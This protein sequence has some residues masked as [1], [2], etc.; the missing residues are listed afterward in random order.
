[1]ARPT[2]TALIDRIGNDISTKVTGGTKLLTRALLTA[3]GRAVAGVAHGLYGYIAHTAK[4]ILPDT[5]D[6]AMLERHAYWKGGGMVKKSA[7]K[8]TGT[9]TFTGGASATILAGTEVHAADGTAY[10]TNADGTLAAG[11]VDIVVTAVE[12]GINDQAAGVTLTLTSPIAGVNS[13]ATV[14]AGGLTGGTDQETNAQLL[15][16]LRQYVA[17]APAGGK[18]DDYVSW[19]LEVAGVT[20]A[21]SYPLEDGDGKVKMRFMMDDTYANGIPL[22]A[23]VTAVQAKLD[24]EAPAGITPTAAAP[25]AVVRNMTISVT[26]NTVAVQA[27]VQAEL[28]DLFRREAEPGGTILLSHIDEAISLA[29]G[30]T[31]H[32]LTVPA[33]DLTHTVSQIGVLGVITWS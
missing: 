29:A 25:V 12:G 3:I 13:Q 6:S 21:W 28:A 8:S 10:T 11:T 17:A 18:K 15:E 20:R 31:D 7:A 24:A 27:A 22:A 33:A 14:A 5:A 30:E 23:D 32:T 26:P 19:A 4:Q 2:L 16:R 1:V 9:V